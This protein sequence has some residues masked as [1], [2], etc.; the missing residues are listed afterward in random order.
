MTGTAMDLPWRKSSYSSD[1]GGNC[2][3]VALGQPTTVPVRDSKDPAGPNL[4]FTPTAW[5]TFLAAVVGGEFGA[6]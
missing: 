2:I 5:R 4:T 3:E 6:A 1:N